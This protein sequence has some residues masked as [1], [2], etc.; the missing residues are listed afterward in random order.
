MSD[1]Y[2]KHFRFVAQ[3]LPGGPWCKWRWAAEEKQYDGWFLRKEG[4]TLTRAGALAAARRA[5]FIAYSPD[6]EE[7]VVAIR[8][9]HER[10]EPK[11]TPLPPEL[12]GDV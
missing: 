7:Q 10:E 1:S 9:P 5:V 6:R 12:L 3:R 8:V 4:E 11:P 2:T